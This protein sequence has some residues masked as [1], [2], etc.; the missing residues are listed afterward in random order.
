[1]LLL[2]LVYSC[3]CRFSVDYCCWLICLFGGGLRLLVLADWCL[4]PGW[5]AGVDCSYVALCCCL[6]GAVCFV[7]VFGWG[8]GF[9]MLWRF[10]CGFVV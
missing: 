4:L 5:V 10:W 3:L 6:L 2:S 7:V 1:M 8:L 9:V